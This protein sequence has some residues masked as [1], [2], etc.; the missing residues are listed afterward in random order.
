MAL[1]L[2]L[3]SPP[4]WSTDRN[5][6][7]SEPAVIGQRSGTGSCALSLLRHE[8]AVWV[9][10]WGRGLRNSEDDKTQP[11]SQGT[12]RPPGRQ[13]SSGGCIPG[14]MVEGHPGQGS[15]LGGQ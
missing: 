13:A 12:L 11:C 7:P 3:R 6:I 14:A 2:L 4:S 1:L 5:G 8:S 9:S 10:T 15:P